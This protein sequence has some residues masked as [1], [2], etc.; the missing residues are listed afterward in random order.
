MLLLHRW[1]VGKAQMRVPRSLPSHAWRRVR[2]RQRITTLPA[3]RKLP[4]DDDAHVPPN[5]TADRKS[6]PARPLTVC[7]RTI[8]GMPAVAADSQARR[9]KRRI[10]PEAMKQTPAP[11][12][13]KIVLGS[14]T[15]LMGSPS[16]TVP[17]ND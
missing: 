16:T 13:S 14:G 11:N 9:R 6:Q 12:I 3:N 5:L 4:S 15:P 7:L 10:M 1:G 8:A 17:L 2:G